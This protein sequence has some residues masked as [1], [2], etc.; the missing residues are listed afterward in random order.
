VRRLPPLTAIEAFIQ[1]ARLGSVKAAASE[2]ALS[3]PALSRRVQALERFVGRPLFERRHQAMLLNPDGEALLAKL[4]PA[5][6]QMSDAIEEMTGNG[7]GLRLRL[8]VPPLFA[9]EQLLPKLPTLR[10]QHP[11][12]HLDIDTQ[13]YGAVRLGD[14]IDAAILLTQGVEVNL[15][16]R[17]IS[18][19]MINLFAARS[20]LG[21]ANFDA[22]FV[23]RNTIL[24]HRDR[25]DVFDYWRQAINQPTLEPRGIDY[26]DSGHLML[27]AVEAGLGIAMLVNE[28]S[29][30]AEE[31]RLV[32][33][34][35]FAIPSPANYWFACRRSAMSNRAV[36]LFHDWLFETLAPPVAAAA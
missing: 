2:L 5:L 19:G 30:A 22:D 10:D 26:F 1:V 31:R 3:S 27:D 34:P 25:A 35:A 13:P 8:A 12:F 6:D 33:A 32:S 36:R 14:G 24:L 17:L 23:A 7:D 4:A 18:R 21:Q 16:G 15:Y 29:E 9:S 11:D 20:L 28:H